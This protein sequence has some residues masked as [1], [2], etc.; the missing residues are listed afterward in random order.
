M[1]NFR[2]S[3]LTG[4]ILATWFAGALP[5]SAASDE[6]IIKNATSAAPEAVGK[7]AAVMNWEMKTIREGKND[8]TR[9]P[10]DPG[11]PTNDPMCVDKNGLAWLHA[12]MNK[13]EPPPGIGFSYM[14]Q[15]GSGA[16]N[17]DPYATQPPPG[18]KW[19]ED[20]PHVMI[21]NSKE[22]TALYPRPKENPDVTK[23][24]VMYPDTPYEHLMIPVK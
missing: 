15:G 11:T 4:I 21:L 24:Y 6:E 3:L 20:P 17:S 12:V 8:F 14:L 9:M 18:G 2:Y 22:L 19:F 16:S 1:R 10:D 5:S 7:D 23:P 13:T